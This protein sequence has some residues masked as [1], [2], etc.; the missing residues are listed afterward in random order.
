MART[1]IGPYH[2]RPRL[3]GVSHQWT[4]FAGLGLA[5]ALLFIAPAG[6]PR[7]A[8][9]VYGLS[10]LALFGVSALLHR[11]R[12]EARGHA[13]MRRLDHSVIYLK[14]AGTSTPV[15]LLALSSAEAAALLALVWVGA[16]AGVL[17][18][19]ALPNVPRGVRA[20]F[21][22]ALGWCV[23]AEWPTLRAGLSPLEFGLLAAGGG[24]YTL[25]ALVYALRRPD[26]LPDVFGFHEVFHLF[27]V[28]AAGCHA[29]MVIALVSQ[30]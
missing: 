24:L 5:A 28:A 23:M 29:A 26:P 6:R 15:A 13:R 10:F 30:A 21:Y 12:W 17:Q 11:R 18:S 22:V 9:L 27:V 16:A 19:I 3:R 8:A 14:I 7:V 4:F 20:A 25:G 2:D 1:T